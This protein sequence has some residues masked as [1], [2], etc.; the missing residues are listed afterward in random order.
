[1]NVLKDI[2]DSLKRIAL[3]AEVVANP[4]QEAKSPG[5]EDGDLVAQIM[6]NNC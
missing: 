2:R 5:T 3:I 6:R 1:M 4:M